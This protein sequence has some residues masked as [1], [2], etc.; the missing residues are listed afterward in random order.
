MNWTSLITIDI[1]VLGVIMVYV[2]SNLKK[3]KTKL[4]ENNNLIQ[5]VKRSDPR[6]QLPNGMAL[7]ERINNSKPDKDSYLLFYI[8]VNEY[9]KI[10]EQ[11]DVSTAED[12]IA[13][14]TA[15]IS[16][17]DRVN[18][19]RMKE[20]VLIL[21]ISGSGVDLMLKYV[22]KV[23]DFFNNP[24]RINDNPLM[25]EIKIGIVR[26][27]I[28]GEKFDRLHKRLLI[29]L[30]HVE[31]SDV[32][33]FVVYKKHLEMLAEDRRRLEKFIDSAIEDNS[34][35]LYLQPIVDL[36]TEE[37]SK[38]EVLLRHEKLNEHCDGIGELIAYAEETGQIKT[39]DEWVIKETFRIMSMRGMPLENL[40]FSINL[41]AQTFRTER[42]LDM[43]TRW[44][45]AYGIP[46]SQVELEI[47]E[48]SLMASVDYS[49]KALTDF[50]N[51]GFKLSLDDFGT[52]YS[53]L[54]HLNSLPF[55]V[56]KIDRSY[57]ER[58]ED[59]SYHASIVGLVVSLSKEL[60]MKS[61]AEGI[62]TTE[63]KK[64]LM[65]LGCQ[66]GQGYLFYKPMS[67]ESF[68]SSNNDDST[69]RIASSM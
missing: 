39:I 25:S 69:N 40:V 22:N 15:S 53:S 21:E 65:K 49:Q 35:E 30:T 66:L 47:T 52:G 56:I 4:E 26:Y 5:R 17:I 48:Y 31:Y 16:R 8:E 43:I 59:T 55:D 19:Y 45:D 62:E 51:K 34:F 54:T 57:I 64:K 61:V 63:Q 3:V 10:C 2:S 60:G 50:K 58:L 38:V 24:I 32:R 44:A 37:I 6:T 12:Y 14:V 36:W 18:C 28:D 68:F 11:Y 67:I 9:Y 46:K 41:S 27:P 20:N 23:S 33:N 29:A 1:L 7:E 13:S 42:S